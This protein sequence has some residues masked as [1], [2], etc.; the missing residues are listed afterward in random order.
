MSI[1]DTLKKAIRASGMSVYQIC[2]ETGLD[3]GAMSRFIAG[4][5]GL[6]TDSVDKLCTLLG[7]ELTPKEKAK[8]RK[9]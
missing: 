9:K 2:K 7:L 8:G 4:K 6:Q 1:T 5:R 3:K